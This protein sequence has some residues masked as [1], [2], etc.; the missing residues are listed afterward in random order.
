MKELSFSN[1]QEL[2]SG[3]P[4]ASMTYI[5]NFWSLQEADQIFLVLQEETPWQTWTPITVFWEK[6][7]CNPV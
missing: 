1:N 2:L 6:P 7:I 5:P 3:L 4:N